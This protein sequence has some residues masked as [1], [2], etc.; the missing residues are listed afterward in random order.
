METIF[1]S[2]KLATEQISKHDSSLAVFC[3]YEWLIVTTTVKAQRTEA[4]SILSANSLHARLRLKEYLSNRTFLHVYVNYKS[5]LRWNRS[6]YIY[7]MRKGTWRKR[8][9]VRDWSSWRRSERW[10][11]RKR[12][13]VS[14]LCIPSKRT[15]NYET[16]SEMEI[17]VELEFTKTNRFILCPDSPRPPCP[18]HCFWK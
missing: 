4:I 11:G 5:C 10:R 7:A 6:W 3:L 12:R 2:T 15:T 17:L 16:Q 9:T 8:N 1:G 14:I 18:P 13:E